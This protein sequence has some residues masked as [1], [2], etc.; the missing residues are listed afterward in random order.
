AGVPDDWA[1]VM[2]AGSGTAALEAMT[3]ASVRPGKKLLICKNGIYGERV[4]TIARRLEIPVI[5]VESLDTEP[6]DLRAIA[7]ALEADPEIDALAIIHHETTTGLLNPVQ[8]I[9]DVARRH[10]TVVLVDAISSLGAEELALD[11]AGIDF[12]ASTSNKCLHG[13]PGAAF[14]L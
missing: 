6:I 13:L 2:L 10:G 5:L 11:G 7:A 8:E 4:E 12:V 9:A 14:I 3:G 1:L